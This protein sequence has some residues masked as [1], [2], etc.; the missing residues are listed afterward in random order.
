MQ[1]ERRERLSA[2][3]SV[4]GALRVLEKRLLSGG[5]RIARENA[6][7]AV[8]EDRRRAAARHDAE[9]LLQAAAER[10]GIP[11]ARSSGG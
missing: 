8:Q 1:R 4:T 7:A 10:A 2:A 6:W 11:E 3:P 5:R 9:R